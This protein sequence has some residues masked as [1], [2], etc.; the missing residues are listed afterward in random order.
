MNYKVYQVASEKVLARHLFGQAWEAIP[1]LP[2]R[3]ADSTSARLPRSRHA[4]PWAS[5]GARPCSIADGR[6]AKAPG[7]PLPPRTGS[8]ILALAPTS[9]RQA[10]SRRTVSGI[11]SGLLALPLIDSTV[12]KIMSESPRFSRSCTLNSPGP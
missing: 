4:K 2:H 11:G 5:A 12:M 1:D 3:S 10:A 6:T 8:A 7:I 9:K